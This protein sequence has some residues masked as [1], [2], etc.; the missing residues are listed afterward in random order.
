[1]SEACST[2]APVGTWG[3]ESAPCERR[4]FTAS[5]SFFLEPWTS[6]LSFWPRLQTGK[7]RHLPRGIMMK[8]LLKGMHPPFCPA[9]SPAVRSLAMT[10]VCLE[11]V[12]TA[13]TQTPS[14]SR[15]WA[16][17]ATSFHSQGDPPQG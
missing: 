3:Q 11:P 8:A 4:K 14:L 2:S 16:L 17:L 13:P 9:F 15:G 5:A 10:R 6:S 7:A 1:M 12:T